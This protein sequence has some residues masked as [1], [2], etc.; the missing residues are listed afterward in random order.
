[1]TGDSYIHTQTYMHTHIYFHI[2][3]AKNPTIS[4]TLQ[5]KKNKNILKKILSLLQHK[6]KSKRDFQVNYLYG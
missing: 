6:D 1:M 3:I 2:Y 5:S 4:M